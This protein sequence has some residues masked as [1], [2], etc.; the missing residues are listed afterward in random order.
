MTIYEGNLVAEGLRFG[1]VVARFNELLSTR[2]LSGAQD[3]LVRHGASEGDIDVAWVPG[4]F[5][6]PMVAAKMA[7]TGRYDAA[8]T[9]SAGT[10]TLFDFYARL[11]KGEASTELGDHAV[12]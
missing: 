12:F 10:E 5:E 7:A 1:I 9:P 4:A 2:L 6:I 11:I 8:K 3:A